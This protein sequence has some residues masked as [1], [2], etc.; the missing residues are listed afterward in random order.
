VFLDL[1]VAAVPF[2]VGM[3]VTWRLVWPKWKVLGKAAAYF[4]GV[5]V[6][7]LWIGHWSLPLA[8]AHQG[9]GLAVHVWFCRR[10]G[11]TWY[12]VEDPERY[13]RLSKEMVGYPPG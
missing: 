11:I 2:A 5:G 1:S 3:A 4:T 12:A 10:H 13:V 6:L 8:F 7:S 9:L